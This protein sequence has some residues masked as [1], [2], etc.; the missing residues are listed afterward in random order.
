ML[1]ETV[2][3]LAACLVTFALCVVGYTAV[4]WGLA[5]L[6]FP[7][8]ASG[9]LVYSQGRTVVGSELIAQ[10]FAS[11][12]Y[13]HPRPSAVNHDAAATGGSNLAPTNPALREAVADRARRLGAT[14]ELP[15]P[16]DL[17]TASGSGVDPHISPEA[18]IYQASRVARARNL[19]PH[20]VR[21][22][23]DTHTERAG[24]ILGAPP[25]VNVLRLNMALDQWTARTSD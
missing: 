1:R 6:V 9:S 12:R 8:Q 25:R 2:R 10:P 11:D 20:R 17:V 4:V 19:P 24:A 16:L 18:A 3:A 23:I 14:A 21:G 7:D 22:L 13:F 15:A 5:Q